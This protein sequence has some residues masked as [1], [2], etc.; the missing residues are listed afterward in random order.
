VDQDSLAHNLAA[1][2]EQ[3]GISMRIPSACGSA[4]KAGGSKPSKSK[5]DLRI[6]AGDWITTDQLQREIEE[7]YA[8]FCAKR[9]IPYNPRQRRRR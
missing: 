5:P 7:G 6:Y 4:A 9:G 3:G 2:G 1:A 8:R